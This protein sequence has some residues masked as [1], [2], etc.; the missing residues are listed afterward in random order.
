M[1]HAFSGKYAIA[2]MAFLAGRFPGK[3]ARTLEVEAVRLA[4]EDA[5]L[6]REDV[7]AAINTRIE[8]GSG[9]SRG[10]TDSY[11]R[12]LGLPA[13]TYFTVQ[14]GGIMTHLAILAATQLLELGIATYVAVGYG[15]TDW[16]DT[17]G[18]GERRQRHRERDGLWG[19]PH[20]DLA[21]A[22]HH[23][24]FASRHMH[25]FGTTSDQLGMVAVSHRRWACLNPRAQMYGRPLT[26][27]DYRA[28]PFFVEPYRKLDLCLQSDSG[29]AF[30]ITTMERARSL[31]RPPIGV[32]GLGLGEAMRELWW[33]KR[34]YTN[35]AVATAKESAFGQ[36]GL[37][38]AD[39]D[40]A[41]LYDCFT[42]EV[43]LQVEDYGWCAKGEGGPFVASGAIAPGG[44]IPV[45]TGGGLLS[46]YYMADWTP[47]VE[48][49][50]QLRGDGGERQAKDAEVAI[51]SGH[52][53]EILRPGMCSTHGTLL[54]G[55]DA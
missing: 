21:A 22:S 31:R 16:S 8:S 27:D 1:T 35:L 40:V 2:G 19:R 36:A 20:G 7:D 43:V 30:V 51:V 13:K 4:I 52:G 54:L 15:A 24:F 48:A 14:R 49:V 12:I 41:E 34:N 18:A 28:S 53:G 50:T 45:N 32:L 10:W 23:S 9:E 39:V 25:E 33:E 55:R 5:G 17:R 46:G 38:L 3:T 26:L 6:R 37:T 47:F 42:T 11:A 44:S 29:A